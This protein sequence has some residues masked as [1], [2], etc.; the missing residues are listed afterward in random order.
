[1]SPAH[2][3]DRPDHACWRTAEVEEPLRFIQTTQTL[4]GIHHKATPPDRRDDVTYYT[5]QVEEKVEAAGN[6]TYRVRET[7]TLPASVLY[8]TSLRTFWVRC[9]VLTNV[10]RLLSYASI[11]TACDMVLHTYSGGSY[12]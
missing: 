11:F 9:N 12:L 8:A 6:K 5:P 3:E 2:L 1:L 10:A 4:V 7:R